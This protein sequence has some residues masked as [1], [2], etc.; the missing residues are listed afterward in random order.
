MID[1]WNEVTKVNCIESRK[2]LTHVILSDKW[3]S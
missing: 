3:G 1:Q 2:N